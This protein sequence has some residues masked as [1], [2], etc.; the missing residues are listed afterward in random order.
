MDL[1][2]DGRL[3]VD[4]A[5]GTATL[6][7]GAVASIVVEGGGAGYAKT[8]DGAPVVVFSGGGGS[9]ATATATVSDD[10]VVT[11]FTI[12]NGG[13]DYTSA[14][15]VSI[16]HGQARTSD[17]DRFTSS[18]TRFY[19]DGGGAFWVVD[20]H[21][22][23]RT[24]GS[25]TA[26]QMS[27]YARL[28]LPANTVGDN[29][30]YDVYNNATTDI[31]TVNTT[32]HCRIETIT[33]PDG[34]KI[35]KTTAA[36]LLRSVE[37][38]ASGGTT[39]K[40]STT[41][42]YDSRGRCTIVTD[43]RTGDVTTTYQGNTPLAASVSDGT[44]NKVVSYAYDRAGRVYSATD[45]NG[46]IT[47]T[48]Y[49]DRGQV[50]QQSGTDA[51]GAASSTAGSYPVQY[52][53]NDYGEKIAM[54]TYRNGLSNTADTTNW[55][56][57]AYT[58]WLTAKIDAAATR[59]SNGTVT[60]A[61]G[62][63]VTFDY[64]YDFDNQVRTVTR[65][66]ARGATAISSY[67][68]STGDLI[69]VTYQ[70][71][72]PSISYTYTR[73][74][75]PS[76]V[77]DATGTRDFTY[78]H[79]Q[80]SA[81]GLDSTFYAGANGGG[82]PGLVLT[83]KY[84]STSD[85]THVPGRSSG[86]SLGYATATTADLDKELA[87]DLGYDSTGRINA[88]SANY[89][90]I[91]SRGATALDFGY[92][93]YDQSSL[94]QTLTQG[95]FVLTRTFESHRNVLTN[96][97]ATWN[98]A[99]ETSYAYQ[100]N[101]AG[102]RVY[103]LQ[104]GA[105]FNDFG[106]STYFRYNYNSV[107]ELTSA[108]GYLGNDPT[109]TTTPLRGRGYGF[110]YDTIGNRLTASV[111]TESVNYTD[112]SSNLGA[113]ALN[114]Y[115][116][117]GTLATHVSG[118][119]L[120]TAAITVNSATAD[121]TSQGNYWDVALSDFGKNAQIT[122]SASANG[123]TVSG[124]TS[125][126]LRPAT[127]NFQYDADG[128]LTY[129]SVWHYT[130]DAE[131]R[132]M[133]MTSITSWG[134]PSRSLTFTYDYLGRRVRK[135]ASGP[136][137]GDTYDYKF[138]YRG[139]SL[140]A[141]I[142]TGTNKIIRSFVW[143][144]SSGPNGGG[145]LILETVQTD[146]TLTPYDVAYDGNGNVA[147]LVS[148]ADGTL[149]AVYEY[150]LYGQVLRREGTE[151]ADSPFRFGTYYTDRESGLIYYGHRYYDPTQG[152]F[153]NRDPAEEAG[154]LNLYGYVGNSP[155]NRW[156]YLGMGE[157]KDKPIEMGAVNVNETPF[158]SASGP[159]LTF[160]DVGTT[161]ETPLFTPVALS[162]DPSLLGQARHSLQKLN[163]IA[164]QNRNIQTGRGA[165]L[166]MLDYLRVSGGQV[167]DT[168]NGSTLI[169][170]IIADADISKGLKIY[171][172]NIA[173][174]RYNN[175]NSWWW[176][177]DPYISTLKWQVLGRDPADD[178]FANVAMTM[179]VAMM[180]RGGGGGNAGAALFATEIAETAESGGMRTFYSVQSEADAARLASG[181]A[182]WPTGLQRA[183]LGEG[184]YA[185]GTRAEAEA[186]AAGKE[187]ARILE[188]NMSNAEYS[189]LKSLDMRLMSDDAAT[190]WLEQYSQYGQG[191]PHGFEHIIRQTGAGTEYYFSPTA[192]G[193]F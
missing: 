182:P 99:Q 127:E 20:E 100:A 143:G 45:A 94:W 161:S 188:F 77:T 191:L 141:M 102:Q 30:A 18:S 112:G 106:S 105:A 89:A 125:A 150:D 74:G 93:Y 70:D 118:T 101:T 172:L 26:E 158:P 1:N 62:H 5:H 147:A 87:V 151:S 52:D 193:K 71:G 86:Y 108:I 61:T 49:N 128:N 140:V 13:S 148:A 164:Q 53:Y 145:D 104:S 19:Q 43:S 69:G 162:F 47:Y 15:T 177:S 180:T 166:G 171:G 41:Y 176:Y 75:S 29:V 186:Y 120:A 33:S 124:T 32:T 38:Y 136:N 64:A 169:S 67:A 28:D 3:D 57:D 116:D 175:A 91:G 152:R 174:E 14:P 84:Q 181:G 132:L 139:W 95:S 72:T 103:A 25:G 159:T 156:D 126:L 7:N 129:D 37:T 98:G 34:S 154:G 135:Q 54:R 24:T 55:T 170:S 80:I 165:L 168:R 78:D 107:G 157:D 183:N 134:A 122:V 79:G 81:E 31:T 92:Q 46:S 76:T 121:R 83:S 160:R 59:D 192:F 184:L 23:Y 142:D 155:S 179:A 11:G 2:K 73:D 6:A 133:S 22:A 123:N 66:L 12:T 63:Q 153:I 178:I 130:W 113:N 82:S 138:V 111:D 44:S 96:M 114:E 50:V 117:R 109:A 190:A 144:M 88:I 35:V 8:G 90:A 137:P 16:G 36:G 173:S 68:L 85:S 4:Y 10:G 42:T 39:P 9:G 97:V 58:G 21:N 189:G 40:Y 48:L 131:N 185:W 17:D 27:V 110:S 51:S 65:T 119:A 146:S 163:K 167:T 115:G 187:G 149:G 60:N 56:Y